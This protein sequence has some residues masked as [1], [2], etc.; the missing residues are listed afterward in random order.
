MAVNGLLEAIK[1]GHY[2]IPIKIDK[3]TEEWFKEA[4]VILNWFDQYDMEKF[5]AKTNRYYFKKAYM[6]FIGW[7]ESNDPQA[8][9]PSRKRFNSREREYQIITD[10]LL[11]EMKK[12]SILLKIAHVEM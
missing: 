11:K 8:N 4:D 3:I 10:I 12:G 6:D 5:L 7:L 2:T 1:N 9:I